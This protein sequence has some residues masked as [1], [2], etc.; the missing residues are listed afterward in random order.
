MKQLTNGTVF[1]MGVN[2]YNNLWNTN[3]PL[4][5]P[6]TDPLFCAT[7]LTCRDANQRFRFE[8]S[9]GV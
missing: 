9:F 2:L 8:L 3:Y 1:G 5:N 7:P 6:Y 4:F